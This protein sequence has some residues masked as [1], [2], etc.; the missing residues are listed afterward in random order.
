MTDLAESAGFE[1]PVLAEATQTALSRYVPF[2]GSVSN[3]VDLTGVV[4][5]N[6]TYVGRCL[7]AVADDPGVDIA[8]AIITFVPDQQFIEALAEA[9]DSTGKPILIVWTGAARSNASGEALRER[10]VPVYDSPARAASGLAALA[11]TTGEVS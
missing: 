3:P 1:V 8:I 4:L 9:F 5:A 6:P 10:A 2:Y 11:A 7:E